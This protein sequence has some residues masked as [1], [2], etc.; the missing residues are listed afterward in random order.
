MTQD[1]LPAALRILQ[2]TLGLVILAESARFAYSPGA[3]HA[4][5]RTGLPDF[6]R[7]A[8]AW[9]EIGAAILFLVPRATVAGG[10]FLIVVLA[11]A[12]VLHLLHGWLDVGALV[13]YAAAT[14]AVMAGKSANAEKRT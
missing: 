6:V 14:W 12:I 4:F 5:A 10:W 8:L 3:A 13:V 2:W 7:L 9:A 11:V 1:R